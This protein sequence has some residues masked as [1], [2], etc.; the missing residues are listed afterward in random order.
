[1]KQSKVCVV[2]KVEYHGYLNTHL[3]VTL[4]VRASNLIL[5]QVYQIYELCPIRWTTKEVSLQNIIYNYDT[6]QEL[7]VEAKDHVTADSEAR[8]RIFSVEAQNDEN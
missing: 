6:F 5:L 2:P 7:W 3:V 1:M 8:A 4:C